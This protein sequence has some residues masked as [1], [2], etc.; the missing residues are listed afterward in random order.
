MASNC[1]FA[2]NISKKGGAIFTNNYANN[3]FLY[4]CT[5][6]N[7]KAKDDHGGAAIYILDQ[8]E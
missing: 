1:T 7:N 2:N 8:G 6:D 4:H 3:V 5:F